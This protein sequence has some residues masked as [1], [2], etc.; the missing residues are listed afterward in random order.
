MTI[1][2]S[3]GWDIALPDSGN[4]WSRDLRHVKSLSARI[5]KRSRRHSASMVPAIENHV[6]KKSDNSPLAARLR[7]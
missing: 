3:E 2:F 6:V 5:R 7:S 4:A 1:G